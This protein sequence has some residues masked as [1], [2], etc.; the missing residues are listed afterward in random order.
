MPQAMTT[1]E[2]EPT[3]DAESPREDASEASGG[4]TKLA[5]QVG[6]GLSQ[7]VDMLDK[8]PATT[9]ADRAQAAKVLDLFVDLIE[10]KLG[11][12]APGQD[13][14]P[15]PEQMPSMISAQGG[16][17]GVPMGPQSRM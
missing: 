11:G 2:Q 14:A 4:A 15:E 10:R 3:P 6:Q 1:E 9:E 13:A 5:Q 16:M 8:S 12:Q 7:L 17:K